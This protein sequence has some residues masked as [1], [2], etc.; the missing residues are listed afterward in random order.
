MFFNFLFEI[1]TRNL[2]FFYEFQKGKQLFLRN[3]K[4]HTGERR[5]LQRERHSVDEE[6]GRAFE[7]HWMVQSRS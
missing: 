2:S 5:S 3:W 4:K 1:R 6:D 7:V